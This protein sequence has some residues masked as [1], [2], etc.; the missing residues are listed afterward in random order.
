MLCIYSI[1]EFEWHEE[2]RIRNIRAH[3]VD[4]KEAEATFEDRHAF[5]QFDRR[6][7]HVE[8]RFFIIGKTRNGA[9]LMTVFTVRGQ[10][11]RIISSR[12]ASRREVRGYEERIRL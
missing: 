10:K 2:K 8:D 4:F 1:V 11:I 5:I 9:L 12:R 6:H 3:T 7:A